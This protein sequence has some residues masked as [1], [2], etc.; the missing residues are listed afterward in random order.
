MNELVEELQGVLAALENSNA[1]V[2]S[3]NKSI[4][5]KAIEDAILRLQKEQGLI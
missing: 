5:V 4:A 2:P 3:R 1:Q